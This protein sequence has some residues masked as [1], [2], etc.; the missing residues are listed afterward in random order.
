MKTSRIKVSVT[1]KGYFQLGT[2]VSTTFCQV[3]VVNEE[4][5]KRPCLCLIIRTGETSA[6]FMSLL[7]ERSLSLE[8]LIAM[9]L[10]ARIQ[11]LIDCDLKRLI[12]GVLKSNFS[13]PSKDSFKS[14]S[15]NTVSSKGRYLT[16]AFKSALSYLET[17]TLRDET[18]SFINEFLSN[19]QDKGLNTTS[20]KK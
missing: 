9:N 5:S 1:N 7:D 16:S 12:L 2:P 11:Q 10:R 19:L 6:K 15:T 8:D 3:G 13:I 14:K 20:E 17:D 18:R 4:G